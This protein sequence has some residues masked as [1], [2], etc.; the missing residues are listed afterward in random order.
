MHIALV[1]HH[2]SPEVGA[3]QRRWGA[4]V[5][6]FIEAGHRVSVL[7]PSPHYP[8]GRR[9]DHSP[10]LDPGATSRGEHGEA[11]HRLRF[12][13]HT[14][15]LTSR[16]ADQMVTAS[17]AVLRGAV[18]LGMRRDRPD[19]VI[20]TVPGMP[21]IGAGVALSR[22]LRVPLV[23]EMRDAWPDL[24][25]PS[26]VLASR[27]GRRGWKGVVTSGAH[28][29]M[30]NLQREAVAIVTTTDAF[31]TVLRARRMPDVHVIRNGAYLDEIPHLQARR[32]S[33]GPLRI[34]Y[35]GTVGRSQGLATAVRASAILKRRGTPVQLRI[36]G[37]G[38]EYEQLRSLAWM[39]GAPV[40]F[41]GAVPREEI[42]DHYAWADSLL[43]SLRAWEPFEWTVPSKLYELLATGRHISGALAG[44]AA[45]IIRETGAGDVV[46]PENPEALADLW[47]RIDADRSALEVDARGRQWAIQNA[48]YDT[49]A[50]RYLEILGTIGS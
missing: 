29:A 4:L 32:G 6:R 45:G 22:G 19:V 14:G 23:V 33:D 48:D 47:S 37:P 30:T 10:E 20:A 21:S 2:Y 43:V 46:P 28:R 34:L 11:V 1:T 35:L 31:A 9:D 36:V 41:A 15:S 17:H 39:I 42:F 12:R 13:E 27:R 44:E 7:A 5:P 8:S 50:G 40:D 49:L 18:E 38:A 3:P 24:I 25:E 26:A 16:T